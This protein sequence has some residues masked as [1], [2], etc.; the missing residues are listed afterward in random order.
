MPCS[1]KRSVEER[2]ADTGI[3]GENLTRA[4]LAK[5][6]RL[7]RVRDRQNRHA[8]RVGRLN[9]GNGVFNHTALGGFNSQTLGRQQEDVRGG[10]GLLHIL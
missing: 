2:V 10:L 8:C 6:F 4:R 5:R 9:S 1:S 3:I 7:E